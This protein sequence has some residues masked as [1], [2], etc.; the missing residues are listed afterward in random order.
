MPATDRV[1]GWR[2][3]LAEAG[4]RPSRM[5]VWHGAFGR[6]AGYL[7]AR[8]AFAEG[9]F[10]AVFVASDEQAAGVLR[11]LADLGLRCPDDVAVASFDGIAE[12]AYTTPGLTTMSQPFQELARV[13]LSDLLA[14]IQDPTAEVASS[15]LPVSLVL[16]GSCGCVDSHEH[17]ATSAGGAGE[18]DPVRAP[19][20]REG[21]GR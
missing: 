5:S 18:P 2:E 4:V 14:R 16:R 11:A 12:S 19:Q 6:R 10:D 13:A 15:V 17:E 9:A 7:A 3:A 1:A 8:E 20:P 21:R